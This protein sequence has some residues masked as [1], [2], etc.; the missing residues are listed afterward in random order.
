MK[1]IWISLIVTF[2]QLLKTYLPVEY[3]LRKRFQN[4]KIQNPKSK[5]AIILS[6]K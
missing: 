3:L 6:K 2:L 1:R 4:F 5:I